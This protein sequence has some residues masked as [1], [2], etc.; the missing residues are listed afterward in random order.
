MALVVSV[1]KSAGGGLAAC[2][3]CWTVLGP[4]QVA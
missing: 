3:L 4:Q 1:G 2:A